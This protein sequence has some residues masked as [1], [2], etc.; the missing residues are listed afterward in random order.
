MIPERKLSERVDQVVSQE[1]LDTPDKWERY[2]N[3]RVNFS[4]PVQLPQNWLDNKQHSRRP[5]RLECRPNLLR[6][7][8]RNSSLRMDNLGWADMV[9]AWLG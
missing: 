3:L 5:W 6:L 7:L 2:L 9:R 1:E 4:R 8:V